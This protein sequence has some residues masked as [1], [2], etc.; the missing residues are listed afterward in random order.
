VLSA[1]PGGFNDLNDWWKSEPDRLAD[2]LAAGVCAG[3]CQPVTVGVAIATDFPAPGS[4]TVSADTRPRG[5]LAWPTVVGPPE[6]T[7]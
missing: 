3:L 4:M 7:P 6:L 2:F 5:G 1:P